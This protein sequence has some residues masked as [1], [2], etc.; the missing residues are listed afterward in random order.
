M[1]QKEIYPAG[2][3]EDT[4]SDNQEKETPRRPKYAGSSMQKEDIEYYTTVLNRFMEEHKPY[5]NPEL[6]LHQLSEATE[7]PVQNLS[8]VI[9]EVFENNFFNFINRYRVEDFKKRVPDPQYENYSI[10]GI[11]FE[12]GFNSKTSF[13]RI[14]KNATG[15]TPSDYKKSITRN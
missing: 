3:N 8:Q 5:L 10:L 11:A 9:N 7:I 1:K 4:N 14:F 15:Q 2:I 6:T 12:S 13:N